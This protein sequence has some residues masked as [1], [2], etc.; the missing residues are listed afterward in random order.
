MQ[1]EMRMK[2]IQE[3]KAEIVAASR[4]EKDV[5]KL[6]ALSKEIEDLTGEEQVIR[7]RAEILRQ[8]KAGQIGAGSGERKD[9][10]PDEKE[11]RG[12]ELMQGRSVTL[13][14]N[15]VLVPSRFDPNIVPTFNQVSSLLDLVSVLN[16]P[17]GE[18]YQGSYLDSYGIADYTL[19]GADYATAETTFGKYM[20]TKAKVTAYSEITEEVLKLPAANYDAEV[21]NG[22]FVALRKLI[23]RQIMIGTGAANTIAG[24]FS[25]AATAINTATDISM[26]AV[27]ENTLDNIIFRYGGQEDVEGY[28]VLILNKN[29]LAAFAR[30][31]GVDKRRAYDIKL[32]GNTGTINEVP[33]VI[34]SACKA[35]SD[36]A[37]AVGDYCMAY[38]NLSNYRLTVFSGIEVM[39]S[40]DFKF[41]QGIIAN[42]GV[43]F[44]GGNV[45]AKN[46]FLRVKKGA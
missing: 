24:I 35:I 7:N 34:N 2:E 17:G 37:T 4:E 31:R 18:S 25:S 36:T 19:E 40:T 20:I 29:D 11:A 43:V 41:K 32:N 16:L 12:R 22:V 28:A 44:V 45:A 38:G 13:A 27:D 33:F 5:E 14:S 46:G 26:S 6:R 30:V 21:T 39:R 3:R 15:G 23:T 42:K 9:G 1:D 8:V 10:A